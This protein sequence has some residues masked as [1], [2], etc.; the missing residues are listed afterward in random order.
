VAAVGVLALALNLLAPSHLPRAIL[1]GPNTGKAIDPAADPTASGLRA[2]GITGQRRIAVGPPPASLS[3]W[4][5]DPAGPPRGTVFLLHGIQDQKRSMLGFARRFTD[6]GYRSVLVDLRCH[7]RSSGRWLSFGVFESADLA[8]VLDALE[9]EGLVTGDVGAFGVS[10]GGAT[11]IQWAGRDPR[12]RA[13]VT[14]AAFTSMRAIVPRYIRLYLPGLGLL[15]PD[16]RIRRCVDRSGAIAGFDPGRA[17]PLEAIA[18]SRAQF[19]LFHGGNDWKIPPAH[20]E[21]LHRAALDHASLI[22]IPGES[23]DSIVADRT[24][25]IL[26]E[27]AAWFDRC[28][29]AGDSTPGEARP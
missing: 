24:G 25:R 7:G 18:R 2:L 4:W 20:A 14:V 12:V 19:L 9:H 15:I 27:S 26:R 17:S 10:Y 28:L 23:H 21:T 8:Q 6:H 11:A 3:V 5:L 1:W 13:V 22:L 16:A 29:A